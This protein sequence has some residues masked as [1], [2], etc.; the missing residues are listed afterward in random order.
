MN[1]ASRF[2]LGAK[3]Y[4]AEKPD[5]NDEQKFVWR[6]WPHTEG[7]VANEEGLVACRIYKTLPARRVWDVIMSSTYDFAEPGFILIDR[8]NEMNK[9]LV[10]GEHPRHQPLRRAAL[11][12][13]W[14]VPVGLGQS[15]QVRDRSVHRRG[16]L[17]LGNLPQGGEGVH[18]QCSTNV[19]EINGLPL[20]PQR[21]EIIRKRRPRHGIPGA[22]FF[23]HH[24]LHEVRFEEVGGVR[25]ERFRARWRSPGGKRRWIWRERRDRRR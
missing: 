19:V 11:A 13:L 21:E 17:R 4:E 6:E 15:H 25:A 5:L 1:G 16:A 9:Q 23:H 14:L 24:A 2:P 18:A 7:Y 3:E 12:A 8:V 10:D 20:A 22:G